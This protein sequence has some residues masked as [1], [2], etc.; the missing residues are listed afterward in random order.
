MNLKKNTLVL[1]STAM[2]SSG[3]LYGDAEVKAG[4]VTDK[5]TLASSSI[6]S[7]DD[8]L[9]KITGE[10]NAETS[11]VSDDPTNIDVRSG[12]VLGVNYKRSNVWAVSNIRFVNNMGISAKNTLELD[13]PVFFAGFRAFQDDAT[14]VDVNLGK[15]RMGM[16]LDSPVQ[17]SNRSVFDGVSV[18][19][20]STIDDMDT[21]F[22][23]GTFLI[24]NNPE[25]RSAGALM[26]Y[27]V[28]NIANTGAFAR[29]SAIAWSNPFA[30][31]RSLDSMDGDERVCYVAENVLKNDFAPVELDLGYKFIASGL[32]LEAK[33]SMIYNYMAKTVKEISDAFG[34]IKI[35]GK[36]SELKSKNNKAMALSFALGDTSELKTGNFSLALVFRYVESLA[37]PMFDLQVASPDGK[38]SSFIVKK[39][40]KEFVENG[41]DSNDFVKDVKE[42]KGP[43]NFISGTMSGAYVVAPNVLLEAGFTLS[44]VADAT[45]GGSDS[46]SI[47]SMSI[48][49]KFRF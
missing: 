12:G 20:N 30:A 10:L 2:L 43:G 35:N 47:M 24:D 40:L 45:Y 18:K 37:V 32:P 39:G 19:V 31:R 14:S 16:I 29:L 26:G 9:V 15:S 11:M 3:V 49:T 7:Q 4:S 34:V 36:E 6:A 42:M 17:Y 27:A 38:N 48:G 5:A 41:A 21:S 28:D 23:V 13:V 44:S 1:L 46:G 25:K 8:S 33:I 22:V